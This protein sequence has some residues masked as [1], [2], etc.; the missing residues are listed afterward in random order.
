MLKTLPFICLLK[1][2]ELQNLISYLIIKVQ[3]HLNF[4][5]SQEWYW[6]HSE[7]GHRKALWC[8]KA[9]LYI[10][11]IYHSPF[12]SHLQHYKNVYVFWKPLQV[13]QVWHTKGKL[14]RAYVCCHNHFSFLAARLTSPSSFSH[15]FHFFITDF[16]ICWLR[17]VDILKRIQAKRLL[18][19]IFHTRGLLAGVLNQNSH[20]G[21]G[22]GGEKETGNMSLF[23]LITLPNGSFHYVGI[24]VLLLCLQ[25]A[26]RVKVSGAL[27]NALE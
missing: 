16:A 10:S 20:H 23:G 25:V 4:I 21:D 7:W 2:L 8:W 13:L 19:L 9:L 6:P 24:I 18:L 1:H 12:Y 11:A 14:I 5:D 22:S 15:F 3:W 27:F 17:V 26:R